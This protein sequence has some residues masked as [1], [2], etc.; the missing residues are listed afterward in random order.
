MC[1]VPL[2]DHS[3]VQILGSEIR[4]VLPPDRVE[5]G[6]Q[7]EALEGRR[8]FQGL[9]HRPPQSAREIDR[10]RIAVTEANAKAMS[11]QA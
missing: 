6:G 5:Y 7:L 9:E 8:I 1:C 4:V 11:A 3:R 10:S 2:L